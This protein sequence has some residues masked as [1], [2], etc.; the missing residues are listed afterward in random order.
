LG[1]IQANSFR[2]SE[3]SPA[4]S[5]EPT[6]AALLLLRSHLTRPIHSARVILKPSAAQ[7]V[8]CEAMARSSAERERL[9][10]WAMNWRPQPGR[11]RLN[12]Y[13]KL[14][15][16]K[17]SEYQSNRLAL[18]LTLEERKKADA[19][20]SYLL[21]KHRG[22]VVSRGPRYT[23][24]LWACAVSRCRKRTAHVY[25]HW[26]AINRLRYW[27]DRAYEEGLSL[28]GV[29]AKEK[30]DSLPVR[31]LERENLLANWHL[32]KFWDEGNAP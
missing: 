22:K 7:R 9:K 1:I 26:G 29:P 12:R 11:D 23:R 30:R 25:E 10:A 21:D 27:Q 20:Y 4:R 6:F 8:Y 24:M 32:R 2:T 14:K 13:R 28:M 18:R 17:W 16:G 5:A 31:D 3:D 19:I 15:F